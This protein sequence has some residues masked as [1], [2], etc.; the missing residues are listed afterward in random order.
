MEAAAAEATVLG[1]LF[2]GGERTH[3]IL[4]L[5]E[6]GASRTQKLLDP[7][8]LSGGWSCPVSRCWAAGASQTQGLLDPK[9]L[10]GG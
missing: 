5:D 8:A 10:L 7:K 2:A 9:G 4:A 1:N 6:A 3:Q